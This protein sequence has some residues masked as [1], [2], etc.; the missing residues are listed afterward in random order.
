MLG[1]SKSFKRL[2]VQRQRKLCKYYS[3]GNSQAK[4]YIQKVLLPRIIKNDTDCKTVCFIPQVQDVLELS[5]ASLNHDREMKLC[6]VS[7]RNSYNFKCE[8]VKEYIF[9]HYI[10]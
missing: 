5:E 9:V 8:L 1:I 7:F 4:C 10:Q 2:K 3:I 6:L